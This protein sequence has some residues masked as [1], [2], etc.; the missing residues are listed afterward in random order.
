MKMISHHTRKSAHSQGEGIVQGV[1]SMEQESWGPS[2][3]F[4]Y[5]SM[6]FRGRSNQDE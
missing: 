3:S 6:P 5:H 2:Q 4:A 1:H